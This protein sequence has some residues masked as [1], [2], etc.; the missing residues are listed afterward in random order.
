MNHDALELREPSAE[1]LRLA[2]WRDLAEAFPPQELE[3]FS[4][5]VRLTEC[6]RYLPLCLYDGAEIV[7]ECF[8]WLGRPGWAV[9]EYLCVTRPLR[10]AGFG[11]RILDAVQARYPHSA[12]IVEVEAPEHAPDPAI[13]ARRLA[14]YLRNGAALAGVDT[15]IFGV[16]YK[17]IYLADA[18]RSDE[19]ISREHAAIYRACFRPETYEKYIQIPRKTPA[20]EPPRPVTWEDWEVE[21]V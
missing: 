15:E 5:I 12:L 19:E 13:A 9:F 3:S 14:F 17:T 11:G 6:G 16:H 21:M 20:D 7:G 10:N 2:Y 1:D 4:N 8:L 18:P